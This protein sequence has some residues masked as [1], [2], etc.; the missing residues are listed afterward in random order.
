MTFSGILF[1]LL[2][3]AFVAVLPI[4]SYSRRFTIGPLM[5]VALLIVLVMVLALIGLI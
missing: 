3:I 1:I 5:I 4:W 2:V